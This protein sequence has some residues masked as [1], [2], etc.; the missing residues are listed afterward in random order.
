M[1]VTA[2]AFVGSFISLV[3]MNGYTDDLKGDWDIIDGDLGPQY[4]RCFLLFLFS[5]WF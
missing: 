3:L 1:V 5:F 2:A 4:I